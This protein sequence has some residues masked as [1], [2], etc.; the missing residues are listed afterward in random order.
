VERLTKIE[1]DSMNTRFTLDGSDAL[2]A[3]L[4]HLCARVAEGVRAIVPAGKL[5]AL[6]LGGGYGRGEGGV[7]RTDLGEQPYNDL[8]FYVLYEGSGLSAVRYKSPI[9]HLAEELT[10]SGRIEVELKLLPLEKFISSPASMFYYDLISGHKLVA[11]TDEWLAKC[12]HHRAAHR[13][14][15]HEA[16]RLLM[17]RCSGLLFAQDRLSR[18]DFT[19]DDADFVGRNLAKAKLC[20]GDVLLSMHGQY[21]WSCRERH[22]RLKKIA[23]E[24]SGETLTPLVLLHEQGVSFKL[25]PVRT[26]R[27]LSEFTAELSFLKGL[28]R[29]LWLQLESR[30][31]GKAFASIE[32]YAVDPCPKCPETNGLKNRLVNA[33]TFGVSGLLQSR[34][35]RERLLRV[36]PLLL[37]ENDSE[38]FLPLVQKE[39]GI[40]SSNLRE[41]VS[42]YETL[43]RV[44]N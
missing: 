15:L 20:F 38:R 12:E 44:Y 36:L 25:H 26:L 11:G 4:R 40:D 14:P 33:R 3:Q 1:P 29:D 34:Y 6:V 7:L 37:W 5:H 35:P 17:N 42:A 19:P 24:K 39:L 13:I 10:R 21:H 28:G 16:T 8:E 31:L 22:K 18:A 41:L 32:D 43:W 2:E 30:R 23:A 27:S 9:Q